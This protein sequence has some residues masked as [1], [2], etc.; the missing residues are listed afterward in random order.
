MHNLN[1]CRWAWWQ[2][3][4]GRRPRSTVLWD[5]IPNAPV[6]E[7]ID[8]RVCMA[9]VDVE[10]VYIIKIVMAHDHHALVLW[11]RKSPTYNSLH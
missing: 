6:Q 2:E 7:V 4:R 1:T 11:K 9:G 8:G 3:G 5:S 10:P